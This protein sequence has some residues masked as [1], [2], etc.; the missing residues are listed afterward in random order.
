[1]RLKNSVCNFQ[2][3]TSTIVL[4]CW[5]GRD[6]QNRLGSTESWGIRKEKSRRQEYYPE[7]GWVGGRQVGLAWKKKKGEGCVNRP[8]IGKKGC[9]G[10]AKVLLPYCFIIDPP[11]IWLLD[12]CSRI[13]DNVS[14]FIT[15]EAEGS[16]VKL[17]PGST[18]HISLNRPSPRAPQSDA[19]NIIKVWRRG[20]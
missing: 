7:Q 12:Q 19:N 9:G 6:G 11:T 10:S 13:S 16:T 3:T 17:S 18:L 15:A 4:C 2:R 5:I 1:M 20:V 14:F 8:C